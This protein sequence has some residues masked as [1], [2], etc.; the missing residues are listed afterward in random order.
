MSTPTET[1]PTVEESTPAPAPAVEQVEPSK[2]AAV[3][4]TVRDFYLFPFFSSLLISFLPYRKLQ[5]KKSKL[6]TQN[7]RYVTCFCGHL[8]CSTRSQ[9][10]AAPTATEAAPPAAEDTAA[11][12]PA[13]EE[14]KGDVKAVSSFHRS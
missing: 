9:D 12:E 7:Q 10:V 2:E 14:A 5:R 4:P 1:N 13:K 8:S 11:A 6:K 3:S